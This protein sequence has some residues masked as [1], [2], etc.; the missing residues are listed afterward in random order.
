MF[1]R[2][3]ASQTFEKTPAA[4][5]EGL[6]DRRLMAADFV[7][8]IKV[9]KRAE[10]VNGETT[11]LN[12]NRITIAF[13]RVVRIGDVTKWRSFGYANDL[14]DSSQQR[15]VT[16]NFTVERD[17][18]GK[19]I[20]LTT[21]RLIR[22]GS[23]L[24]IDTGGLTDK[25]GNSLVYMA[26]TPNKTITFTVGQNKPRYTMSS[27]NWRPSELGYFSNDV[28]SGA[29]P[30]TTAST[31]PS[32]ATVRPQLLAFMSAK[33]GTG[34]GRITAAQRDAALSFFDDAG[35]SALIPAANLRAA[36]ASLIGTVAEPA[37]RS[38]TGS[39]NVTGR[40]FSIIDFASNL[41]GSVEVAETKL[42]GNNRLFT[43]IRSTYAGE[44]FR[45]LSAVL[46]HEIMHQDATRQNADGELRTSQDEEIIANAVGVN[47]YAQQALVDSSFL[48]NGTLLVTKLN[49][50]LLALLNSG[51]ALFPYGGI[52][53]APNVNEPGNVFVGAKTTPGNFGNNTTV[54]SFEDWIR[55][56]YV[57]R[58]F[59]SGGTSTNPT[60]VAILR[61]IVGSNTNLTLFGNDTQKALDTGNLVLVDVSYIR[62]A[63]ALKLTY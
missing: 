47:V 22:K 49:T 62:L 21:D 57:S 25:N 61:N 32:A 53:Q 13:D 33:V 1:R 59:S 50:Q 26:N 12:S 29:N 4:L 19:I 51:D 45:A 10:T 58:N 52:K 44:D 41:S 30:A 39:S 56:E 16:V 27:R 38:F 20:T 40:P 24:T 46:A 7:V 8:G 60:A 28:F 48:A 5:V 54:K 42:S 35:Y 36:M 31:T 6:E 23:R 14:L 55:R 34:I 3:F 2:L 18:T 11:A 37:I 9:A 63:S 43:Q 17:P 15:K